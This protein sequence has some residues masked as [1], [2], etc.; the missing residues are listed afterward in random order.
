MY[1]ISSLYKE[2]ISLDRTR[3]HYILTKVKFIDIF[4]VHL[5]RSD[6]ELL[7]QR[8]L[9]LEPVLQLLNSLSKGNFDNGFSN[10]IDVQVEHMDCLCDDKCERCKE[11]QVEY[12][13]SSTNQSEIT[14]KNTLTSQEFT[15]TLNDLHNLKWHYTELEDGKEELDSLIESVL[16]MFKLEHKKK[17]NLLT[18]DYIR[19][20][21]KPK[22]EKDK[23]LARK[24]DRSKKSSRMIHDEY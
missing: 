14:V 3:H 4:P 20:Y 17:F 7:Q 6:M 13:F 22:V 2:E 5:V 8:H 12:P 15:Y 21:N 24:K 16:D 10:I 1:F 19:G 23:A 9:T 11:E 18:V